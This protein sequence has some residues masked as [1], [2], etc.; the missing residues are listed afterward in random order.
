MSNCSPEDVSAV[1]VPA[2]LARQTMTPTTTSTRAGYWVEPTTTPRPGGP[3][4]ASAGSRPNMNSP[5]T[6][7]GG[8]VSRCMGTVRNERSCH[9]NFWPV[10]AS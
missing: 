8:R 7:S 4:L 2:T 1:P 10:R 3:G 6:R 5:R 9:H